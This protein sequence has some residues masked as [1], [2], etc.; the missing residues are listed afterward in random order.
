[1]NFVGM[2]SAGVFTVIV[3]HGSE[4]CMMGNGP[5]DDVICQTSSVLAFCMTT[6]SM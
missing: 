2:L 1:M 5:D 3:V 6:L 4:P